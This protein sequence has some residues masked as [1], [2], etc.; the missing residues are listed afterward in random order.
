MDL[1]AIASRLSGWLCGEGAM[2]D[3]VISCRVRLARNLAG[4]SFLTK[5]SQVARAEIEEKLRTALCDIKLGE[6][7]FYFDVCHAASV[8]REVLIERQLISRYH[9]RV[10]GPRGVYIGTG[11]SFSAMVNE[12]DHIRMQCLRP[13]LQLEECWKELNRIDDLIEQRVDYAFDETYGYLTAC[14]TNLGTAIRVSVMLHLPALKMTSEVDK[15]LRAAKD[16]NLTVRGMQGEGTESTGDLY[17][18]SNQVTLGVSE[19]QL[20]EEFTTVIVPKIV[21]YERSA[22]AQFAAKNPSALDDKIGRAMGLLGNARLISSQEALQLLSHLRMAANMGRVKNIDLGAI[23]E[24]FLLT[25]PAHLQYN[26]GRELD[27]GQRDALRAQM[28]R[29]TLGKSN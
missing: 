22:R 3:I 20:V 25:Q 13:G 2:G 23:N 12:E 9:A 11:E 4:F 1:T 15:V 24:L 19:E 18:V 26:C 5:C 17:Q 8:E 14:P 10:E 21:E 27:A 16:M 29:N 7:S 28:L 6:E